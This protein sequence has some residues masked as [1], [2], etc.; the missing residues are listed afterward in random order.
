MEI[1]LNILAAIAFVLVISS[2]ITIVLL[3]PSSLRNYRL[4]RIAKRAGLTFHRPP[5]LRIKRGYLDPN[6]EELKRAWGKIEGATVQRGSSITGTFNGREIDIT[7]ALALYE[8]L[9]TPGFRTNLRW[10]GTSSPCTIVNGKVYPE[11]LPIREISDF[12]FKD[13]KID[14]G[15]TLLSPEEIARRKFVFMRVIVFTMISIFAL[16]V[17]VAVLM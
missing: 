16:A 14:R 3:G 8:R 13:K 12:V 4:K 6:A 17:C 5:F 15:D 10:I 1:I 2:P 9:S 11:R 7:D